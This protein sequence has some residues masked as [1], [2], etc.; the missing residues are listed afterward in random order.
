MTPDQLNALG[1]K[2][3]QPISALPHS[4]ISNG[5]SATNPMQQNATDI[6]GQLKLLA[7]IHLPDP[8]SWW[9]PAPGWWILLF[10]TFLLLFL[11]IKF[12]RPKLINNKEIRQLKKQAQEELQLISRHW[13]KQQNI[14]ASS[15][16][17][18][19]F[20][21]KLSLTEQRIINQNSTQNKGNIS[22]NL[23]SG[24]ASLTNEQWLNYIKIKPGMDAVNSDFKDL[25]F[26]LPYQD[27]LLLIE[28]EE[29]KLLAIKLDTLLA[30]IKQWIIKGFK[31]A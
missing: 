31:N 2:P 21:R 10:L 4:P 5:P 28:N 23:R 25:L 29:F 6:D 18:S 15:A 7:D 11:F 22:K 13:K 19:E 9:P 8:L 30:A 20:I 3:T 17:V 14:V 1:S 16:R 26:E 24:I 27:P 12:V